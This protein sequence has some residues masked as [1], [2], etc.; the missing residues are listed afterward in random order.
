MVHF[1]LID[2]GSKYEVIFS[3]STCTN[4]NDVKSISP[5]YSKLVPKKE[6]KENRY[7]RSETRFQ[8]NDFKCFIRVISS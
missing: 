8:K 3:Q 1:K 2:L 6:R 4:T 7:I 5:M